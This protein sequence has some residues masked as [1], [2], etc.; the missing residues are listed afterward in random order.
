MLYLLAEGPPL[1]ALMCLCVYKE[2]FKGWMVCVDS[3][4]IYRKKLTRFSC[5]LLWLHLYPLSRQFTL[6]AVPAAQREED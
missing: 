5:R 3:K 4:G 2:Q 6:T 1:C